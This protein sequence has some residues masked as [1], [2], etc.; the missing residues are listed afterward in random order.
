MTPAAL[1]RRAM[2]LVLAAA[3]FVALTIAAMVAYK[4]GASFDAGARHYLFFGN[5]F[6]DLGVTVT[7]SGRANTVSHA[8]F[9]I[10]LVSV[11]VAFAW[12][13]PA[14]RS[15]AVRDEAPVAATIAGA[16]A[17]LG[18]LGF[19]AIAVTPR[20]REYDAHVVLVQT[21]FVFL[22]V[23]VASLVDV[24]V[25]NGTPQPWI[26]IN[27][28]CLVLLAAYVVVALMGPGVATYAGLRLQVVAQKVVV[29]A[30][31]LNLSVQ[32][33]GVTRRFGAHSG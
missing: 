25:R 22:L 8:L 20:N 10:A 14:W 7:Y 26:G 19:V 30:S 21:A 11:G 1:R 4:G 17:V 2:V 33:W 13:A 9:V 6:S 29:Y 5:F 23:F 24:Q 31:I 12:S 28:A 27:V 15:W 3:L 16:V 18:G 32:A